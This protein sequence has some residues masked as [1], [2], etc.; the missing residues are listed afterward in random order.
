MQYSMLAE[1]ALVVTGLICLQVC[2]F[3]HKSAALTDFSA[4]YSPV[5]DFLVSEIFTSNDDDGDGLLSTAEWRAPVSLLPGG[6]TQKSEDLAQ[7]L[8]RNIELTL[9]AKSSHA[10]LHKDEL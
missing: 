5:M 2:A 6:T 7:R 8:R 1:P 3:V 10:D 4:S 9:E